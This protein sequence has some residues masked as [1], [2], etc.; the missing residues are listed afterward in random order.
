[1]M[2]FFSFK[3]SAPF[4]SSLVKSAENTMKEAF[5]KIIFK[6]PRVQVISNVT[7]RPVRR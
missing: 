4:H 3:K 6:Q 5:E 7:A 1:M 2:I